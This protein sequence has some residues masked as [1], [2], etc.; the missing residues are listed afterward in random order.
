MVLP[1]NR[2]IDGKHRWQACQDLDITP[3]V[4]VYT[5][6]QDDVSLYSYVCGLNEHRRQ[7]D[8]DDIKA[9]AEKRRARVI[10]LRSEE[11]T[12]DQMAKRL[13]V[14][15]TTIRKDIDTLKS[16]GEIVPEETPLGAIGTGANRGK[17]PKMKK[18]RGG[19]NSDKNAKSE[20]PSQT[21]FM[22]LQTAWDEHMD[23]LW[24]AANK[25]AQ[26]DFVLWIQK[27]RKGKVVK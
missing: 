12:Q 16:S 25:T 23:G 24:E 9:Q 19:Q 6:P 26:K 3:E 14:S 2:I 4:T 20:K 1:D 27:K 7:L 15:R 11:L 8:T 22:R 5:G 13:K 17:L 10:Q 21:Q 18:R